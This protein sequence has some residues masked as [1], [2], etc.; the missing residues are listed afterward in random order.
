[1]VGSPGQT[2]DCL[3]EDLVFLQ[4]LKP[5][6]V[7]I[8][9]FIPHHDTRF[10]QEP[11]GGCGADT[12]SVVSDPYYAAEGIAPGDHGAWHHGSARKRKRTG[13]GSQRGD[14]QSVTGEEPESL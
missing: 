1:M 8:G 6:M 12:V 14:A 10:A 5:Q 4:K 9:P 3:A 7:G 13:A 2:D 11:A